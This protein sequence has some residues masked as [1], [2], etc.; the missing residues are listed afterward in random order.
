MLG[1][2]RGFTGA[3]GY[4]PA[5][6]LF[7][8][9][10]RGNI[11]LEYDGWHICNGRDGVVDLSDKFIIGA[12]MNRNPNNTHPDYDHGWQTWQTFA[13]DENETTAKTG[14]ANGSM[15]EMKHLPPMDNSIEDPDTHTKPAPG[16]Y[17]NAKEAKDAAEHTTVEPLID[18]NYA[19]LKPH[20][21]LLI[22]YGADPADHK[23]SV[24]PQQKFPTL[25]PFY[26]MAWITFVGYENA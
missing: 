13:G 15:I 24:G 18:I 6:A 4:G 9:N 14:G 1:E 20:S 12:H 8:T 16:L 17:I 7:N 2:I 10:G 21:K 11:G 23:G 5:P 25:P 3:P 26:C 22:N 19:N